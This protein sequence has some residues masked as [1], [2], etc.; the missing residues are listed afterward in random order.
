[1]IANKSGIIE[2][3]YKKR[4]KEAHYGCNNEKGEES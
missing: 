3:L 1:M 2:T 4:K